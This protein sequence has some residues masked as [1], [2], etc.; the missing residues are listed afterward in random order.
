MERM[1]QDGTRSQ[2][3]RLPNE[4]S[5]GL[6]VAF[7]PDRDRVARGCKITTC[8]RC[9]K[10]VGHWPQHSLGHEIICLNCANDI[11]QIRRHID[12]LAKERG[13]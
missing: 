3:I 11:P 12:Q 7:N 5:A 2:D 1:E 10:L 9:G 6:Y 13:Q 4:T 8:A